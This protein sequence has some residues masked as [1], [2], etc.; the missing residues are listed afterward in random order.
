MKEKFIIDE[1]IEDTD[2]DIEDTDEDIEDN[3]YYNKRKKRKSKLYIIPLIVC[4]IISIIP[5]VLML[6]KPKCPS[7]YDYDEN[8]DECYRILE[9]DA[10]I[11]QEKYCVTGNLI[12]GKCYFTYSDQVIAA[13]YYTYYGVKIYQCPYGYSLAGYYCYPISSIAANK[14]VQEC[15]EGYT[16]NKSGIPLLEVP[17]LDVPGV[18]RKCYR[19]ETVEPN[20]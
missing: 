19:R 10:T 4:F 8:N 2:E 5:I 14:E 3:N 7:E 20:R 15:P 9:I 1:D 13:T 18:I 12:N 16:F 11:V 6:Y 17:Q